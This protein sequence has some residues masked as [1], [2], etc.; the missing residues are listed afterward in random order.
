MIFIQQSVSLL[1]F[2]CAPFPINYYFDTKSE[3]EGKAGRQAGRQADQ[4]GWFVAH[5]KWNREGRKDIKQTGALALFAVRVAPKQ[6][7]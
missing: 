3:I 4:P 5:K 7:D 6:S 2:V 1:S